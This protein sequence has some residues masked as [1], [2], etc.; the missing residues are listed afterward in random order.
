MKKE[1]ILGYDVHRKRVKN[2]NLRINHNME[3]YISAP[4]NLHRDY[5]ENFIRSK[6]EWIKKVLGKV[7]EYKRKKKELEYRT[8]E[9][10]RFLGKEYILTVK[11]SASNKVNLNSQKREIALYT[12]YEGAEDRKKIMD[13]WYYECARKVFSDIMQ[14]WLEILN[15]DI[16]NL[17]IKPMKT[18][19]GSCNYNK[20]YINL[21]VELIKRSI[22]EIEYVILHELAHIKYPNHGKGFYNYVERHMPNYRDAEKMLNVRH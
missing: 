2:I 9:I 3:V 18:R 15:E 6:E 13:R 17:S 1:K 12:D 7:E 14:K 11:N 20:R 19:W 21:N 8:G 10:H 5:I 4:M 16:E 22:F